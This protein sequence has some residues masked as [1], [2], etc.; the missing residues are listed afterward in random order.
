[1]DTVLLILLMAAPFVALGAII[2]ILVVV[3]GSRTGQGR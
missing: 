2:T 1:M 3:I